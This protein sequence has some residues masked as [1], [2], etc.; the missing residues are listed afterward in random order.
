MSQKSLFPRIAAASVGAATVG[1]VLLV[2]LVAGGSNGAGT[3]PAPA[4]IAPAST[5]Q[6]CP[7]TADA[8]EA[9]SISRG[10]EGCGNRIPSRKRDPN[11]PAYRGHPLTGRQ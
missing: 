10:T 1:T 11:A 3:A 5:G 4:P 6:S 2:T 7:A 9:W 8:L